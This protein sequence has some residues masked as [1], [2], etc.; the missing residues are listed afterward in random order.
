MVVMGLSFSCS[1]IYDN[2]N[3][4]VDNE[5][6]Y[7]E[8][9]DGIKRVQIGYERVE[10]DLLDAGRIPSSRIRTNKATK[11]VIECPDFTE[12]GNRRVVDS[13]CSWVNVTGL[14]ELKTYRLTIYTEDDHGN[15]SLP[16]VADVVPYT[17][18]NVE[19]LE[20]VYP[21][22]IEST[23]AAL[24][25]WKDHISAITHTVFR[26]NYNYTD[27]DGLA[28]TGGDNGDLPSFL[29]ENVDKGKD[30]PVTMTCRIIPKIMDAG[31]YVSILDSID[32]Q[33][34][35]N[36]RISE[37]AEPA[38]FLKDPAAVI[39]IDMLQTEAHFPLLFTWAK[40]PE[41]TGYALL[42]STDPEFPEGLTRTVDVG[43]AGEYQV[44]VEE[45]VDI[46]NSLPKARKQSL[47]WTVIPTVQSAPVKNQMR[48]IDVS[49]LPVLVGRWQFNNPTNPA[50]ATIG[51]D[52]IPVGEGFTSV[53]G[54]SSTNKAIRVSKGSHFKCLHGL[55]S[56]TDM[57]TIMVHV[58]KPTT[59]GLNHGLMQANPNNTDSPEM[60]WNANWIFGADGIAF[61]GNQFCLSATRWHQMVMVSD[62]NLKTF[63][64][65]GERSHSGTNADTRY[66]LN[67]EGLLLFTGG[68]ATNYDN[69]IDV[70][71]VA[72]WDMPLTENEVHK[73]SGLQR[74]SKSGWSIF[75]SSN[76]SNQNNLI[77]GNISTNWTSPVSAPGYAVIDLGMP[78]DIGRIIYNGP[79]AGA[80]IA[81][82]IQFSV[83]NSPNSGWVEI[84]DFQRVVQA[85]NGGGGNLLTFNFPETNALGRYLQLYLPDLWSNTTS[86]N[87][88][89]ISVY[90][91][92]SD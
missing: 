52:L 24:M 49:R 26:Y 55:P 47:Y 65:E 80:A 30:V 6:I 18:E 57:Y 92:L 33:T 51:E 34:T 39:E 72:I 78:R 54:P 9:L 63:Y 68:T 36:L 45:G 70:A 20:L 86:R 53:E 58:R 14:T 64:V 59:T 35:L 37:N 85:P 66:M 25:E 50:E 40:V 89:E 82:T 4:Y 21:T 84:A 23:S 22:I 73:A 32:W 19:A 11:T 17:K 88:G 77:D 13:I 91:K 1:D 28:R 31:A 41:A 10:I 76:S 71:E 61:P 43:N 8:N 60:V 29:I 67:K 16:L 74:L 27:K 42:I 81:K 69:D 83:S 38:I 3:K 48:R 62:G 12:P 5:I 75:S 2:I 15:K 87:T 44:D 79:N 90:E 56:G 7:V 46:I